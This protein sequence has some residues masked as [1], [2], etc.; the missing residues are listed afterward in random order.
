MEN[1]E[2]MISSIKEQI[3]MK[4]EEL[5]NEEK[6]LTKE[7]ET[8][9]KKIE[10]W[11]NQKYEPH[12]QKQTP[13]IPISDKNESDI[14]PEVLAFDVKHKIFIKILFDAI[15]YINIFLFN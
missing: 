4:L 13:T 2:K 14:L 11:S 5:I 7:V 15:R 3:H 9:E 6:L 8:F 12:E 1:I 10:N